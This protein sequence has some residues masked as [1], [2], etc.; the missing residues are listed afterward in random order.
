MYNPRF[1]GFLLQMNTNTC[2]INQCLSCILLP[3]Q[4]VVSSVRSFVLILKVHKISFFK[5]Y[6]LVCLL[7]K[8]QI[9]KPPHAFGIPIVSLPLCL[10]ISSSKNPPLP[11]EFRKAVCGMVWIFSGSSHFRALSCNILFLLFTCIFVTP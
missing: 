11:L 3:R 5:E 1:V 7:W 2:L 4:S 6:T 9:Q 10:R 8:S